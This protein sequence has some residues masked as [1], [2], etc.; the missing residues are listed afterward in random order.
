MGSGKEGGN[1]FC[2]NVFCMVSVRQ[3]YNISNSSAFAAHAFFNF[4]ACKLF[5]RLIRSCNLSRTLCTSS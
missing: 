1:D 5:F 4:S 3:K 2:V